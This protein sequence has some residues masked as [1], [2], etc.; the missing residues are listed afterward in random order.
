MRFVYLQYASDPMTFFSVDLAYAKP[1][2]LGPDR[3]PD[4][5]PDHGPGR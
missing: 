3:G 4:P 1:D 5:G 2:W